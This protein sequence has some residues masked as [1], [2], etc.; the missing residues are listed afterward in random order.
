M[1]I[2][3]I[4]ENVNVRQ[5]DNEG[6]RKWYLNSFFDVILWYEE[7]KVDLIGFQLCYSRN[8]NEKAFTWTKNY[9]S[10]RLVSDTFFEKGISHMSTGILKGEGGCIPE[11]VIKRFETETDILGKEIQDLIISKIKIYNQKNRLIV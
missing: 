8:K 5:R 11:E 3:Q 4:T 10:N 6:F 1:N 9:S 7:N 2:E